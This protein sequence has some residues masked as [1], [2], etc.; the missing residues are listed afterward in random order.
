MLR[1]ALIAAALAVSTPAL[2]HDRYYYSS[3][4]VAVST[5]SLS[6]SFGVGP[7][8]VY[9]REPYYVA[10]SR[11]YYY[12]APRWS[13]RDDHRWHSHRHHRHHRDDRRD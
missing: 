3:P 13:D 9:V 10:P 4:S 8:V 2:A 7:D 12:P 5:P 6:F 11:Y 1:T